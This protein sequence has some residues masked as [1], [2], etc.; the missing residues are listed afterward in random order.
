CI[1][2]L[3]VTGLLGVLGVCGWATDNKLSQ[4]P[5]VR[6]TKSRFVRDIWPQYVSI[7]NDPPVHQVQAA[8][9]NAFSDPLI[10]S[11]WGK[12]VVP[13]FLLRREN[14]RLL[15]NSWQSIVR[16]FGKTTIGTLSA[17]ILMRP[18]RQ[19]LSG[20]APEIPDPKI[21]IHTAT[22][23]PLDFWNDPRAFGVDNC[24]SM[25]FGGFRMSKRDFGARSGSLLR[26]ADTF[27]GGGRTINGC[28][29]SD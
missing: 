5:I 17:R 12:F 6:E 20:G 25:E 16:F 9:G 2:F 11:Y 23:I 18:D 27:F 22:R 8:I 28:F 13:P 10:R 4:V 26:D 24:L 7:F 1:L 19:D 3:A 21:V 14:S 29:G 15:K